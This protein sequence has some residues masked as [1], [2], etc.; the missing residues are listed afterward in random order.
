VSELPREVTH[1]QP[2]TFERWALRILI[3]LLVSIVGWIGIRAIDGQDKTA[4]AV[5]DLTTQVAV[6]R[7]QLSDLATQVQSTS[8]LQKQVAT[9]QQVQADHERR[10]GRIEDASIPKSRE[11]PK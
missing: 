10:L 2:S 9:M 8:E 5:N 6:M 7:G 4:S 11:W 1:Y 3:G